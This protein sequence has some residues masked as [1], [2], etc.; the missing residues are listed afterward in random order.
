MIGIPIIFGTGGDMLSATQDFAKMFKNPKQYGL[1]E[2]N[3]IYEENT[4][5]TCGYFID[6]MWYRPGD[7]YFLGKVGE[8]I[9][10]G[11]DVNGNPN[12]WAAELDLMAER[13]KKKGTDNKHIYS[14]LLSGV[15]HLKRHLCYLKVIYFLLQSCMID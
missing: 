7:L 15:E 11:V 1:A 10:R 5:G 8:K 12:C 6:E 9:Y 13:D 3:N 4:Q 14:Q 2:Y